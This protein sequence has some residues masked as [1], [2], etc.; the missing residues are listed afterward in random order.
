VNCRQTVVQ[1]AS[2]ESRVSFRVAK[3]IGDVHR[4]PGATGRNDRDVDGFS[5]RTC[6]FHVVTDART[7]PVDAREQDLPCSAMYALLCPLDG[8]E[9]G[10]VPATAHVYLPSLSIGPLLSALRPVLCVDACDYA[11]RSEAHSSLTDYTWAL[12]RCGVDA[13]LVGASTQRATDVIRIAHPAAKRERYEE[14][15]SRPAGDVEQRSALLGACRDVEKADLV[16][17]LTLDDCITEGE[18]ESLADFEQRYR[19]TWI[20]PYLIA[21][22]AQVP[23]LLMWDDHE[24]WNDFDNSED[25]DPALVAVANAIHQRMQH[26]RSR[27]EHAW[28]VL[29]AGPANIFVLDTRSYR[30]PNFSPDGPEKSRNRSSW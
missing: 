14:R 22:W 13:H 5:N 9:T 17:A 28:V 7:V 4:S 25:W 3:D 30:S 20:D 26:S 6:E 15:L 19:D 1:N 2:N 29:D 10:R 18:A 16:G 27:T 12:D 23:T 8:I 24:T 11:L 21:C